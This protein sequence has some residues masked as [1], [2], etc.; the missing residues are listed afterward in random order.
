MDNSMFTPNVKHIKVHYKDSKDISRILLNF[1]NCPYLYK[2]E[3]SIMNMSGP[4]RQPMPG[5]IFPSNMLSVIYTDDKIP[6]Y[7]ELNKKLEENQNAFTCMAASDKQDTK[8]I[9]LMGMPKEMQKGLPS[10]LLNVLML[11]VYYPEKDEFIGKLV[12]Y[13]ENT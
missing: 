9:G 7:D 13:L 12:D 10:E 8:R 1:L 2:K 5:Y 11:N 3:V 6:T 4:L